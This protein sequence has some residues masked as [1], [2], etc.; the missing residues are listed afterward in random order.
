MEPLSS[1]KPYI[2]APGNHDSDC[3]EHNPL[4]CPHSQM[5][6]SAFRCRY[7][8][9]SL[10]S[11]ALN[12]SS[13]DAIN[14]WF[15]FQWGRAYFVSID[16]ETDYPLSPEGSIGF[17]PFSGP[18]GT[19]QFGQLAWLEDQLM[20][21]STMRQNGELD[22]II[23]WGH[24]PFHASS[25]KDA[26][27]GAR[28]AFE[29]MLFKYGV[30]FGIFGHWHAY[31]RLYPLT[32]QGTVAQKDYNNPP[33]PVYIISGA[34]GNLDGHDSATPTEI[35]AFMDDSHYTFGTLEF[36]N[37]THATWSLYRSDD[38]SV[39]DQVTVTKSR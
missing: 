18:Y 3:D 14:M 35:T 2:V 13:P 11:N 23:V 12:Y 5:N 4:V 21:A 20:Q 10:E 29:P 28:A 15:S 8:M 7:R 32:A 26:N 16:T 9:P 19:Y 25:S 38:G 22:W 36:L 1:K 33:G 27:L 31:E 37:A 39:Q 17:G 6:F 30:D 34:A 24:R